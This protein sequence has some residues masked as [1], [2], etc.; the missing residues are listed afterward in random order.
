MLYAALMHAVEVHVKQKLSWTRRSC[1]WC[2]SRGYGMFESKGT[3]P[4]LIMEVDD[5]NKVLK[6]LQTGGAIHFHDRV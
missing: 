2:R 3:L 4:E 6:S 1:Q 5:M